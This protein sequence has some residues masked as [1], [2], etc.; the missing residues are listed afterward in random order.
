MASEFQ[1]E[2]LKGKRSAEE[3]LLDNKF[4]KMELPKMMNSM[5][6]EQFE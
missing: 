3:A 2:E 4:F 1:E 6:F 5:S